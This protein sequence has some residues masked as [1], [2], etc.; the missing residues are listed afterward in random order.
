MATV[1]EREQMRRGMGKVEFAK[2]CGITAPSYLSIL[3]G[4]ANPTLFM[5]TR[6]AMNAGISV[7]E[8]LHGYKPNPSG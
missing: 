7:H 8:L 3:G 2:L 4:T 6:I 5:I 1:L